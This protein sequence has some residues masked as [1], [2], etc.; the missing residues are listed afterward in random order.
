MKISPA[1]VNCCKSRHEPDC[2]P[3]TVKLT[4]AQQRAMVLQQEI[5]LH[6]HRYYVLDDPLISDG[7][8]DRLFTE[9]LELEKLF[10]QLVTA[11][12]PSQRVG[13]S[14]LGQYDRVEHR[15]PMLSL[16]NGFSDAEIRDFEARLQRYLKISASL[17]YVAEPKLDGLAVEIVYENGVLVQGSTRGDGRIGEDVTHNI[18]TI[19]T[20]PL[21]L[22]GNDPPAY[23]EV[24]GEVFLNIAGFRQLNDQRG[25]AGEPLFANPRNA[26]AGSLRQLDPKVTSTRP[27]LFFPY[28]ISDPSLLECESQDE[29]LKRLADLGFKINPLIHL[30]PNIDKV[31]DYFHVLGE[32]R[33]KLDYE[34]DG[35]VVKVNSF[36]VQKRLG[37]KARSPRWALACKFPASQSTTTLLDVEF[38]VGRTGAVTP[39]AI[40]EPILLDGAVV[41]R[42][43]LHNNDEISR[44][45]LRL[46]DRVLVQRAGDVIPE[47]IQP[48]LDARDG[49]EKKIKMPSNCPEC[50]HG[51]LR[52]V[53]ETIIRCPNPHCPAQRLQGLIHFTGKAG[54]DVEGLGKKAM[55]QLFKAGLV[56]DIPDIYHLQAKDLTPLDGWAEKSA[57]NVIVAIARSRET[58]LARFLAALGIRFIGEVTAALLEKHFATIDGLVQASEKEFLAVEGIGERSAASLMDYFADSSV[59]E[60]LARLLDSGLHFSSPA[61]ETDELP[62]AA[63][64]F[65][66]T[67]S[68]TNLSRNEAKVRVKE[69][70]GQVVSGLSKKV[71]HLVAGEKAGSKLK[72]AKNMDLT[73]LR[74][75]A[76]KRLIG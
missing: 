24:R 52:Q 36:A 68:L 4:F 48:I 75:E 51:L 1:A 18:R 23:L 28:G 37:S 44:K 26:A 35:M 50:G 64:T 15:F 67:G 27:L 25:A 3:L 46:G 34:I 47:I 7:E 71:T 53:G 69:L 45:D 8:Y 76:F 74:E 49:N 11:D 13:G 55:E 21:H 66:F 61:L 63:M 65:L 6:N 39:V 73:I 30:C 29:V 5:A 10:P 40:L 57:D 19:H 42:A 54:M 17:E 9:L 16:E 38:N 32:K 2:T 72:K 70:G 22:L 62:L 20:I 31:V 41:S 12:S 33:H 58:T 60:M 59:R 56:D 14:P 43:T